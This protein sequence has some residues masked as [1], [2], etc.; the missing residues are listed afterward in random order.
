M[1]VLLVSTGLLL[2][3]LVVEL[4]FHERSLEAIPLR[5]SIT[6]TRGKSSVVRLLA[7]VLREDGRTVVAKTTGSRAVLILPDGSEEDVPRR[8]IPSII[9]Q[10]RYV[11]QAAGVGADVMVLEAMSIHAEN[12][13]VES[14]RLVRPHIVAIT[15]AR[16]DHVG[17]MGTT[18]EEVAEVLASGITLDA[19]VYLPLS[20]SREVFNRGRTFTEVEP[21]SPGPSTADGGALR[22]FEF[23]ENLDLVR[24]ISHH[25]GISDETIRKGI[26]AAARDIGALTIW[27]YRSESIGREHFLVNAFASNDPLSTRE[28][29]L[30]VRDLCPGCEE[31]MYGLLNLRIDRGDRTLQWI[32]AL[33]GEW[34]DSFQ[35]LHVTGGHAR[36]LS[37]RL[38]DARLLRERDPVKLTGLI[39]SG[40]PD[41]AVLFGFGNIGGMGE[42]LVDHWSRRGVP[43]GI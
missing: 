25:L 23:N 21:G 38:S 43:H 26:D 33:R 40:L 19:D 42:S 37:R 14:H 35:T 24:G 3:L 32:D 5:I 2:A 20:E 1:T 39:L 30:R 28:A 4:V 41:G 13:R 15:N 6:G 16:P 29:F 22:S 11:R 36:A 10:K 8:G 27:R 9:E 34:A 18:A 7:S 12:H 17:A 31:R